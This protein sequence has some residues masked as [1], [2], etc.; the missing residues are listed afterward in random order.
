MFG[1]LVMLSLFFTANFY[2]TSIRGAVSKRTV[3]LFVTLLFLS[4]LV[5]FFGPVMSVARGTVLRIGVGNFESDKIPIELGARLRT[6]LFRF[7]SR[8]EQENLRF[9]LQEVPEVIEGE[10]SAYAAAMRRRMNGL[11][12]ISYSQDGGKH[13]AKL[14]FTTLFNGSSRTFAREARIETMGARVERSIEAAG[15]DGADLVFE[16]IG[17]RYFEL[18]NYDGA[19]SFL[20]ASFGHRIETLPTLALAHCRKHFKD[21]HAATMILARGWQNFSK[22][23]RV[24]VEREIQTLS[25][26]EV[27]RLRSASLTPAN[28]KTGRFDRVSALSALGLY[29]AAIQ[30]AELILKMSDLTAGE[31][32]AA[33]QYLRLNK[34]REEASPPP[35]QIANLVFPFSKSATFF[36]IGTCLVHDFRFR[37]QGNSLTGSISDDGTWRIDG[38]VFDSEG[39]LLATVQRGIIN[40]DPRNT[41]SLISNGPRTILFD[42]FSSPILTIE[43]VN[44]ETPNRYKVV[45][46]ISTPLILAGGG[47]ALFGASTARGRLGISTR[48][49]NAQYSGEVRRLIRVS[50]FLYD[51]EGN[52]AAEFNSRTVAGYR[53]MG[54]FGR[55]EGQTDI[56]AHIPAVILFG[57]GLHE[58]E[59]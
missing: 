4:Y 15:Q 7:L 47:P 10:R 14:N 44:L 2:G 18:E 51:S 21:L 35:A 36:E 42:R 56:G 43:E 40:P 24:R 30:E 59:R 16:A 33:E 31:R 12:W 58:D 48:A 23:D 55:F 13:L 32:N 19:A 46:N 50:G 49:K 57:T 54:M 20:G 17:N 37:A 22:D 9:D 25:R 39:H 3:W 53:G 26:A 27:T 11:L 5:L 8:G 34:Q 38:D 1:A 28:D 41:S 45:D 52:L 6:E 29:S